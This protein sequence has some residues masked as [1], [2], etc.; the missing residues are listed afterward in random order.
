LVSTFMTKQIEPMSRVCSGSLHSNCSSAA[1]VVLENGFG[2]RQ[3]RIATTPSPTNRSRDEGPFSRRSDS[4]AG[5][6]HCKAQMRDA[7]TLEID[8]FNLDEWATMSEPP[9]ADELNQSEWFR[10][11]FP[12]A[13]CLPIAREKA[14]S[15]SNP[16]PGR[17]HPLKRY[18]A[19][20]QLH[21]TKRETTAIACRRLGGTA[22]SALHSIR[23]QRAVRRQSTSVSGHSLPDN[24]RSGARVFTCR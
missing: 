9:A 1:I 20:G 16:L 2:R 18:R 3:S 4:R 15:A 24:G 11:V 10:T 7:A 21:G 14:S 12:S 23:S 22:P 5:I 19:K 17:L 13:P 8:P 6:A